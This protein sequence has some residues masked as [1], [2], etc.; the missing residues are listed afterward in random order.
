MKKLLILL[1]SLFFVS[2]PLYSEEN[3]SP[4]QA[5]SSFNFGLGGFFGAISTNG[6]NYKHIGLRPEIG[7]WKFAIA[8]DINLFI[9]EDGK[10]RKE[11]W[12]E[13]S[14]YLD[15]IY[16]IRFGHRGDPFYF[17][18]GGIDSTTLGYGA[19]IN[20]YN[21]TIDYPT[22]K[23]QGLDIGFE[24]SSFGAQLIVNDF[25]ELRGNNRSVM[26]G[27]RVFVKPFSRMQIGGSLAADFNEYKGLYDSDGDGV[28]DRVDFLPY[29]KKRSTEADFYRAKGWDPAIIQMLIDDHSISDDEFAYKD[30]RSKTAF[31]SADVGFIIIN[32]EFI[33]LDIYAQFA[34]SFNTGGWGFSAP[35]IKLGLGNFFEVYADYRYRR[36]EFIFGYYN[37][38]Y[39]LE[40]ARF[41]QDGTGGLTVVTKKENLK[42]AKSLRGYS[43]GARL[44]LFDIITAKGEY[45]DLSWGDKQNDR[46]LRAEAELNKTLIPFISSL[47]GFYV[48]NNMDKIR[49]KS[50]STIWGGVMGIG[51]G[52]NAEIKM[53]YIV[54]YDDRNGDGKISGK[55]ETN[56]QIAV[57][58][59]ARF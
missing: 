37:D 40:R 3:S 1:V 44:N 45:A 52:S 12:N 28:P 16:Y 54:T 56:V 22:Y 27:G 49:L 4:E 23:R 30:K 14:D 21:N 13:P 11:D 42:E 47:K 51:L 26:T 20:N 7:I 39:D 15:K 59:E 17:K 34:Q 24:T 33:N 9:D 35:G 57:S 50:A 58:T 43:A 46:S 48:Q 38:T 2:M 25:K 6:Q 8:L 41:I 53:M 18:V 55:D 10:I 29:D 5:D 31:W 32:G 19:L 36:D